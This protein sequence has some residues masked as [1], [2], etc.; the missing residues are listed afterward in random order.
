[1]KC[2]KCNILYLI[3]C[4]QYTQIAFVEY[5]MNLFNSIF[6]VSRK[7]RIKK[8]INIVLVPYSHSSKNENLKVW[9]SEKYMSWPL[10]NASN[11]FD[12]A[13]KHQISR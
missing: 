13:L 9:H 12:Y 3:Q 11:L 7:V 1:M 2:R 4:K 8:S 6:S 10:R 5:G